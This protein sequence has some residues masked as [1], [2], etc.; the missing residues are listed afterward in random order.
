VSKTCHMDDDSMAAGGLQALRSFLDRFPGLQG[1]EFMIWGESYAGVYVPTLSQAIAHADPPLAVQFLG[2]SVGNP[3]TNDRNQKDIGF[4]G[5]SP[6]YAYQMGL[7]DLQLRR[8]LMQESCKG[9]PEVVGIEEAAGRAAC[10]AAWRK[11][12]LMTSDV[13]EKAPRAQMPG[14]GGGMGFLDPYD[15]GAYIGAMNPYWDAVGTYL[16]RPDVRRALHTEELPP[17][18]LFASRLVYHKQYLACAE[19]IYDDAP[20]HNHSV[21]PIYRE[22]TLAGYSVMLYSGDQDPSVQWQGSEASMRSVGHPEAAGRGW[23]PWFYEETAASLDLL[24]VKAPEWGQTLSASSRRADDAVLGG[25]IVEFEAPGT[26]TFAT[27]R[28]VGHMVP[29]FRPIASLHLFDRTMSAAV[30]RRGAPPRL[31]PPLPEGL[32]SA[33]DAEWYGSATQVGTVGRWLSEAQAMGLSGSTPQIFAVSVDQR[34]GFS[35][36]VL[37]AFAGAVVG[38]LATQVAVSGRSGQDATLGER[39]L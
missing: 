33:S 2:F 25:Y 1:R 29:Q 12:D 20:Q 37:A 21:L 26:L 15:T 19:Q 13:D 11:F 27:V 16:N 38:A 23:R 36:A 7:I 30:A 39:L 8:E 4:L 31:A 6:E 17:W 28:G 24:A 22:L 9:S 18:S 3:C 5:M 14:L 10:P 34:S 32:A 35:T